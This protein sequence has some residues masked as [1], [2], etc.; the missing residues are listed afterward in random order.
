M[1]AY[2]TLGGQTTCLSLWNIYIKNWDNLE[3]MKKIAKF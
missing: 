1:Y 3:D 2:S